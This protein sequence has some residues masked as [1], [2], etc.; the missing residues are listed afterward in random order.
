[1]IAAV[2][3]DL[4]KIRGPAFARQMQI[5]FKCNDGATMIEMSVI[6][7]I[8]VMPKHDTRCQYMLQTHW[9]FLIWKEIDRNTALA[10]IRGLAPIKM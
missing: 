10:K 6:N 2:V 8:A 4:V 5:I 9:A 3:T 7:L 1:M